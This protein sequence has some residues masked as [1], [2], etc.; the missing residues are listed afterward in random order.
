MLPKKGIPLLPKNGVGAN[1][2]NITY[3]FFQKKS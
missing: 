2:F 3:T 1:E